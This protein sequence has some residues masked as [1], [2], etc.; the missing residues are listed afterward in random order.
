MIRRIWAI[1]S[2]KDFYAFQKRARDEGLDMGEALAAIVH[3]Y[4][5]DAPIRLKPFKDHASKLREGADYIKEHRL[6]E[7]DRTLVGGK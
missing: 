5:T 7:V 6:E 4:A 2:D 3:C 1:V